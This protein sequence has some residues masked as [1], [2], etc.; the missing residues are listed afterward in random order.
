[1]ST[2]TVHGS[3]VFPSLAGAM[4][5]S[6]PAE[7]D[8]ALQTLA[9]HK[10]AWV[11]VGIEERVRILDQLIARFAATADRWVERS[12]AA[13]NIAADAPAAGDEWAAGVYV[14]LR[15]LRLMRTALAEVVR[16]GAPHIPH[17]ITTLPTGQVAAHVFPTD[18]YDSLFFMGL[19]ADVWMEPGVTTDSLPDTMATIY[20][21]G[22]HAGRIA[23]VL[24]AG[25]VSS[26]APLDVLYKLFTEDQVV[27]LKM[28]PVNAYLGPLIV[29]AFE[30][31]VQ[32]GYLRVAYGGAAEGSYLCQHALVD[33]IHV[34]G[35]DKTFDA[36]VFGSGEEGMKRKAAGTPIVSKPVT[37]ELGNVSPVII[38]P[39]PWSASDIA[40][41]AA[42]ISSMLTNNAG[43]NC[44]ATRVIVQHAG[45]P[46]EIN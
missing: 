2:A 31:L 3:P 1:M 10:D 5:H 40:Y 30:P 18:T 24:G 38:V 14:T 13:K 17:G 35:S 9:E 11:N 33:T 34:T 23:L 22:N 26:I 39:G 28:N 20:R 16:S 36:I 12:L 25:N 42:H 43:F 21:D 27:L 44:N 37:G 6:S 41:Q 7:L 8:A 32:R 4:E 15:H 19:K 45:W 46:S 29:E